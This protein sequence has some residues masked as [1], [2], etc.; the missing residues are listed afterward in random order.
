MLELLYI[1]RC[2]RNSCQD[3]IH[4]IES[5]SSP[6]SMIK[7]SEWMFFWI[8]LMNTLVIFAGSGFGTLWSLSIQSAL[9]V[10]AIWYF[11]EQRKQQNLEWLLKNHKNIEDQLNNFTRTFFDWALEFR[12]FIN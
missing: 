8:C 12:K 9:K 4:Y 2:M 5:P 10:I 7:I 3:I 6:S 11:L 1:A